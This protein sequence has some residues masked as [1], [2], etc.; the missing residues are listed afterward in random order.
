MSDLK[1]EQ[2]EYIEKLKRIVKNNYLETPTF[3]VVTFGCQ[4]NAKDSEKLAGILELVGFREIADENAADIVIFNT[5]TVRENANNRLYGRIGQLKTSFYKNENK[6]IGIC[7]CMMQE[8]SEVEYVKKKYPY[9]KLIFGTFNLFKFA[10]ILYE[11]ISKNK[12]VYE[13]IDKPIEI[14]DNLPMKNKYSFKCGVNIMYGC[15]NFCSYCIVPYVRG[16][17]RSRN[18]DD[19]IDEIKLH[20]KNGVKEIMLLGQNVNSYGN[21]LKDEKCSFKDI[22][23]RVSNIEGLYR[24]R[25]M[26]SHPKDFSYDLID[27][28]K[29]SKTICKHI[30]LPVQSGSNKILNS[31]NRK[32]TREHYLDIINHI[33]SEIKNIS[34]TTDIIVGY[35]TETEDD[36]NDTIDL[37][38]Q[39]EFDSVFTFKYSKREGTKAALMDGHIADDIVS[40]RFDRLLE[41]VREIADKKTKQ[42]IGIESEALIEDIE[43]DKK[44]FVGRLDNNYLV[45]FP[46]SK[47]N[48]GDIARVRLKE[49]HNFYF[50]GEEIV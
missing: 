30:H 39:V 15:N 20:I 42:Y 33:K 6:I 36:F 26:T 10:E 35:P 49:A 28:I 41:V 18:F 50:I 2:Y 47:K 1:I 22:L 31:M 16:R 12:K 24:L 46:M 32:Y 14:V 40:K 9:V 44:M 43:I 7:G 29:K 37:I 8:K 48:I 3:C 17:E 38:K 25:F 23:L 4:M 21:D 45:Y 27:V 11:V 13:V 34:I 19:I 5:C